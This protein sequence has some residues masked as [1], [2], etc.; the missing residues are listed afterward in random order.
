MDCVLQEYYTNLAVIIFP[1]ASHKIEQSYFLFQKFMT[2]EKGIPGDPGIY[3]MCSKNE[4]M[5]VI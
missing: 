5:V 4:R 3:P 2:R 1:G